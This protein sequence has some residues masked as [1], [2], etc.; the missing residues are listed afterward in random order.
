MRANELDLLLAPD[1]DGPSGDHWQARWGAKLSTA[2]AIGVAAGEDDPEAWIDAVTRAASAAARPVVFIAHSAG[3]L[4]VALAA[5]R[6]SRADVRGAFLVAPPSDEA[7]AA[8]TAKPWPATPR[9]PL[10]WRSL[11]V[12][13][14][15]DPL[16]T[17][18]YSR[19]LAEAW[20]STFVDAGEAGRIDAASE[21]GPWPDGLLRLA[22]FL[23]GL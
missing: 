12:A 5:P 19:A 9:A 13:S 14:R 2:R 23:K 17:L 4:A 3:A 18:E 15:A 7:L 8:L 16:A 6:L 22:A 10:P 20:G 11:L 21:H 1:L